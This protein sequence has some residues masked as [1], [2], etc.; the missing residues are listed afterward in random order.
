[1]LRNSAVTEQN[2]LTTVCLPSCDYA[3]DPKTLTVEQFG[4][5]NSCIRAFWTAFTSILFPKLNYCNH[6][7]F[8]LNYIEQF[9]QPC[10]FGIVSIHME[11]N[12]INFISLGFR[13]NSILLVY[14]YEC[15]VDICVCLQINMSKLKLTNQRKGL[16]ILYQ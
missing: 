1:M 14:T 6:S 3:L 9:L 16:F 2:T 7:D 15:T 12:F 5:I 13:H 4:L 11:N 10:T 8:R